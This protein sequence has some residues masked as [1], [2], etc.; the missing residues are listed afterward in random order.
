MEV[1]FDFENLNVYQK[2]LDFV[3]KVFMTLNKFPKHETFDLCSH[4]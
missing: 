1:H 3:D 4:N 2:G